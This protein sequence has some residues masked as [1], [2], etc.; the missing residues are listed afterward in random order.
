[1]KT[2]KRGWRYLN[3]TGQSLVKSLFETLEIESLQ[4]TRSP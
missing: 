1:M 3:K 4:L 2:V